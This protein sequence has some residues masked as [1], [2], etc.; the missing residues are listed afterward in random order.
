MSYFVREIDGMEHADLLH[1]MNCFDASF[2]PLTSKH[3]SRGY[4]WIAQEY[5]SN[6]VIAFAGLVPFFEPND[7]VGYFKRAY[8]LPEY[9]GQGLQL[10]FMRLREAKARLLKWRML[11]SECEPDNLASAKNFKAA[12]F[13]EFIPEQPWYGDSLYFKKML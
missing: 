9:R 8:V 7:G 11:V 2:P 10:S 4:W 6:V 13:E 12:G 5:D 1:H 3:L